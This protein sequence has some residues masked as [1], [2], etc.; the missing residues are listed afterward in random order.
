MKIYINNN[1]YH[2]E[3]YITMLKVLNKLNVSNRMIAIEINGK[4]IP[5]SLYKNYII[6]KRDKIENY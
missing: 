2:T 6:K 1:V 4:V 3:E 5:K